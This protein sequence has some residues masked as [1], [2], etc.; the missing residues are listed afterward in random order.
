MHYNFWVSV[1]CGTHNKVTAAADINILREKEEHF[2]FVKGFHDAYDTLLP[3]FIDFVKASE[4]PIYV[5]GHSLGGA[6]AEITKIKLREYIKFCITFGAP[7]VCTMNKDLDLKESIF[8]FVHESDIVPALPLWIAGWRHVGHLVYLTDEN[9]YTGNIAYIR[10]F[11]AQTLP[12]IFKSIFGL[13]GEVNAH[14]INDYI[15]PLASVIARHEED[16]DLKEAV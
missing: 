8:R 1:F 10:R 16:I 2:T 12:I 6:I 15:G 14:Y 13:L 3:E 5:T 7:R 4:L 11:I 9:I